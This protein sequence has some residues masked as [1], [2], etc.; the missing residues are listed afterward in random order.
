MAS[1]WD[2]VLSWFSP[3]SAEAKIVGDPEAMQL[4]RDIYGQAQQGEA[5]G[6][7]LSKVYRQ[8]IDAAEKHAQTVTV[9]PTPGLDRVYERAAEYDT[10]T[11]EIRYDPSLGTDNLRNVLPHELMHF[12]FPAQG[13]NQPVDA[14]HELIRSVLGTD[15]YK[16]APILEG[17]QQQP[18]SKDQHYIL[19]RLL[20]DTQ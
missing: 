7:Y 16:E 20:G 5:G 14:Q 9:R 17:F 1:T 11:K 2:S 4:I 19:Q 10:G 6:E 3:K 15:T 13:F 8:I 12:L 18:L